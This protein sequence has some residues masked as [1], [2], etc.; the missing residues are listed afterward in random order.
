MKALLTIL[1]LAMFLVYPCEGPAASK[2]EFPTKPI[3]IYIGYPPGGAGDMVARVHAPLMSKELGVPVVLMYKPGGVGGLCAEFI[4]NS[5]PDG[6]IIQD[7]TFGLIAARHHVV[8]TPVKPSDFTFILSHSDFNM[9][10]VVRKDAPWKTFKD[11]VEYARKNP[12]ATYGTAG[13]YSTAHIVMEWILRREKVKVSHIPFSGG[14]DVLPQVLGGHID[15]MGSSGNH[16]PL[17]EAGKL[18][19]LFQWSGEPADATKVQFLSELYP[20]FPA[21][22]MDLVSM[23]T[24]LAGPKGMPAP[25]VQKLANAL[26]KATTDEGF[27]KLMNQN[28][29]RIVTWGTEEAAKRAQMA[30]DAFGEFLKETGFV[31]K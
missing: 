19:T 14:G 31:K 7:G 24:G 12:A 23:P 17:V 25:I 30:D 16:L 3:Q 8:D 29:R 1:V 21:P 20:D 5:K 18:R 10:F 13:E 27:I 9:A 4:A 26:K 28:K 6:Y 15:L 22:L 11:W 2:D